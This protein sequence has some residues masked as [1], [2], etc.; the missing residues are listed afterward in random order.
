MGLA[1]EAKTASCPVAVSSL[2]TA[3]DTFNHPA[4]LLVNGFTEVSPRF[5]P[6]ERITAGFSLLDHG[7]ESSLIS[8]SEIF[9]TVISFV[10][11]N[12]SMKD[13]AREKIVVA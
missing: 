5:L 13:F 4:K 12:D 3:K 6:D 9:L 10:I 2:C 7:D 1:G 11:E 8:K